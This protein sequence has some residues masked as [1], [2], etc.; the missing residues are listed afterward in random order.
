MKNKILKTFV[1]MLTLTVVGVV[2][3]GAY[4]VV[5]YLGSSPRFEV[6]KISVLGQERVGLSQV[7]AQAD[8]SDKANIFSV[9]LT[10]IR[11][12]VES[13]KWVRF[14]TVQRVL[15]DTIGI[16][17]VERQ[18]VGLARIRGAILQFDSE[19]ELLERDEGAGVNS[20]VLDGLDPKDREGNKKKVDLYL[21]IME[22]LHGQTELSQI[23]INDDGEVSVV[24][25]NE[26]LLVNLGNSE[27]RKR[28]GLYLE[29]RTQIQNE[30]PEAVQVDLRFDK[31]AILSFKQ[32]T[33][34]EEKVVWDVEKKSL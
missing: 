30:Y 6:R 13:L 15:P 18:P 27:F 9:D 10:E 22:D 1:L 24:S 19:G 28:W 11:E 14:A 31:Q 26:P 12:R 23:R 2:G 16:K 21:R 7:L 8:L 3:W 34:N 29:F 4:V 33:P 5:H 32:D 20:P 17:I 25:L